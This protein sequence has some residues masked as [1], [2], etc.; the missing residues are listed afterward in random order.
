M[1]SKLFEPRTKKFYTQFL[2]KKEDL[3]GT[4]AAGRLDYRREQYG[5]GGGGAYAN[6]KWKLIC[7]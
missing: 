1:A 4:F 6:Q 2:K 3:Y 7:F 5:G